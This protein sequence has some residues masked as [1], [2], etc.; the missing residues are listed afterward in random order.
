MR[1]HFY[2]HGEPAPKGSNRAMLSAD[3]KRAQIAEGGSSRNQRRV[4]AWEAT[5]AAHATV[6]LDTA[7]PLPHAPTGL[8]IT[9]YCANPPKNARSAY[10]TNE[11]PNAGDLDKLERATA[12]GLQKSGLIAN[13]SLIVRSY[14]VK[15]WEDADHPAGAEITLWTVEDEELVR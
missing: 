15:R 6:I 9:F 1:V 11:S 13:D 8:G 12:D 7:G 10:P 4:K 2:V 14:T 3:G 5:V